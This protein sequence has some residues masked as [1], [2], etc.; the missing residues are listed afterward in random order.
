MVP[1][2][3]T[4]HQDADIDN[5]G[6]DEPSPT[7][8]SFVQVESQPDSQ[9]PNLHH[10][11]KAG[12]GRFGSQ[13][14]RPEEEGDVDRKRSEMALVN[15]KTSKP[16]EK[17][18]DS[19]V[20]GLSDN[21]SK[22]YDSGE[23]DTTTGRKRETT[24]PLVNPDSE[25]AENSNFQAVGKDS[26][27]KFNFKEHAGAITANT[28]KMKEMNSKILQAAKDL[29][30]DSDGVSTDSSSTQ[31]VSSESAPESESSSQASDP[32]PQKSTLETGESQSESQTQSQARADPPPQSVKIPDYLLSPTTTTSTT[33]T[34][35]KP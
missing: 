3:A 9:E 18:P 32:H 34:T 16:N 20:A 5:M 14:L 10:Y 11:Q 30:G 7:A 12:K 19:E 26:N 6:K 31:S 28:D 21:I 2:I 24:N 13:T 22:L 17:A 27:S 33:T 8:W 4:A 15:G 25:K 1:T 35:R 29:E 23:E